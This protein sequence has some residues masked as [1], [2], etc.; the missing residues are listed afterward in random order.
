M[1]NLRRE[2]LEL[3]LVTDRALSLG[4]SLREIV[5]AAVQGGVT[6]VQLR[7][8]ECDTREFVELGR[9][10]HDLLRP[11]RIPLI[12]NDRADIAQVISAEG[13]HIGQ[14]DMDY[15]DARRLLGAEAIIGLSIENE[16][17]ARECRT[18]D[19]LDY[20]GASPVFATPTKTDTAEALGLAGVTRLREIV[21]PTL[22][23]VA[24]GGLKTPNIP[25]VIR[26]GADGVAVVSAIC[27]AA[28]PTEATRQLLD[29]VK[30]AKR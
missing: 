4:R 9:T 5:A 21:G 2:S 22:P 6:M 12:I 13:L 3:Y 29:C 14:H 20:I 17:Q 16:H 7:E 25:D 24:I 10:L 30:Q 28:S 8:K 27:S 23:M 19:G 11:A 15:A 26:A 1:G 18:Y